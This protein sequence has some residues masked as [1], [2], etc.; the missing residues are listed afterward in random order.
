MFFKRNIPIKNIGICPVCLQFK[1]NYVDYNE[2]IDEKF[3]K[4]VCPS[5]QSEACTVG[6]IRLDVFLKTEDINKIDSNWASLKDDFLKRYWG[7]KQKR[8]NFLKDL[9]SKLDKVDKI[10]DFKILL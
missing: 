5:C 1:K 4:N 6:Y 8:I 3:Y 10:E 7:K 9:V 2:K